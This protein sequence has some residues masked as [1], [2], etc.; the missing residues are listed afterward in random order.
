MAILIMNPTLRLEITSECFKIM[1]QK[2]SQKGFTLVE[3]MISLVI[4]S[5]ILVM[6]GQYMF[7]SWNVQSQTQLQAKLKTH[8]EQG[9]NRISRYLSQSRRLFDRSTPAGDMYVSK[10]D[11]SGAPKPVSYRQLPST[12]TRGSLSLEK[13]CEV[14]PTEYFLPYA[15]GNSLLFAELQLAYT[16]QITSGGENFSRVIDIYRFDYIYI[17]DNESD[18]GFAERPQP[19]LP[20]S[21]NNKPAQNLIAWYSMPIVDEAQLRS[22]MLFLDAEGLGSEKDAVVSGLLARGVQTAWRRDENNANQAFFSIASNGNLTVR[23]SDYRLPMRSFED[24]LR[25]QNNGPETYSIAYNKDPDLFPIRTQVPFYYAPELDP[26]LTC[27]GI[28][29]PPAFASEEDNPFPGGFEVSIIGPQSGRSVLLHLTV[30]G[31]GYAR[32]L[33]EQSHTMTTYARDL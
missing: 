12:R 10:L 16:H 8:S 29:P 15:V 25:L 2:H 23:S 11:L 17:T 30:L 1:L 31:K 3:M 9:L 19:L 14:S 21:A 27:D 28:P 13:N 20:V 32:N 4:L 6:A 7:G 24:A 33:I 5:F 26:N 18:P 22:L